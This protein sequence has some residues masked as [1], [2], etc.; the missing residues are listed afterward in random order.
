MEEVQV[1]EVKVEETPPKI[2]MA[3]QNTDHEL[4]RFHFFIIDAGWKSVSATVIRENFQMIR[5]FIG[6]DRLYVL[7]R[8][9]S[10][11]MIRKNP[12]LIGKDPVLLVHDLHAYKGPDSC[13]YHG[14]RLCLGVAKNSEQALSILQEFLRFVHSHRK[15]ADIEKDIRK[16]LHREGLDGAIEVI[17]E[18]AKELIE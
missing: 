2:A 16:K 10:I 4:P 9:Q 8:E 1:E 15:S 12:G 7:S 3:D 6:A 17:S 11:A 18:R 13:D 14:F 5:E